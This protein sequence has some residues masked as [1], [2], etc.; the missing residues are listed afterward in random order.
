MEVRIIVENGRKLCEI[1]NKKC[2]IYKSHLKAKKRS[3]LDVG[4]EK[5]G[6][7]CRGKG[8]HEEVNRIT[9]HRSMWCS[10]HHRSDGSLPHNVR[11]LEWKWSEFIV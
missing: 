6:R 9:T 3:Q 7:R 1:M 10:T 2:S 5:R 8:C 4:E 11:V